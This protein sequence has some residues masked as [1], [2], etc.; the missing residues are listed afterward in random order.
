MWLAVSLSLVLTFLSVFR[1][2]Q[3]DFGRSRWEVMRPQDQE[4]AVVDQ[5]AFLNP[6]KEAAFA[7]RE[8]RV[9]P[10][11]NEWILPL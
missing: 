11:D 8:V 5:M 10:A 6:D 7:T 2:N 9:M 1:A 4:F 3:N